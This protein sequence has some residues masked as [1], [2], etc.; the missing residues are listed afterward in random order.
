MLAAA[1][2]R[3]LTLRPRAPLGQSWATGLA[4]LTASVTSRAVSSRVLGGVADSVATITFSDGRQLYLT[5]SYGFWEGPSLDSYL[6]GR[7][8]RRQLTLTAL[9]ERRLGTAVVGAR[10]IHDYQPGDV[11]QRVTRVSRGVLCTQTWQKDSVLTR[12]VSRT[13]DTIDYT[14][15]TRKRTAPVSSSCSPLSGPVVYPATTNTLRIIGPWAT[16][17]Q[18]LTQLTS[19]Y[20][21]LALGGDLVSAVSSNPGRWA[22]RPE[23]FTVLQGICNLSSTLDSAAIKGPNL[24]DIEAGARYA[25]GLGQVYDSVRTLGAGLEVTRLTAFRKGTQTWRTF[26]GPT[27]QL[28]TRY[29][30]PAATTAV[31]PNPFGDV[32]TAT[33]VLARAQPVGLAL[34]DALGPQVRAA[35]AVPFGAGSQRLVLPTA[36]LPA[37]VYTLHLLF[38]GEGRREVLQVAKA[39]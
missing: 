28:A 16:T 2:G 33:C 4:G 27:T 12:Q 17:A 19:A 30:R 31:F 1:N 7:N 22:G 24:P 20:D 35:A 10:A 11:F 21:G 36:G 34:Y 37:G 29:V 38:G 26:F 3:T 15:R 18:P 13:G 14:I 39:E 32:L 8:A 6:N 5:K 25:T 23:Y 9:P